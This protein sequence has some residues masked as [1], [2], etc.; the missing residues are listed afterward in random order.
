MERTHELAVAHIVEASGSVD[1]LNPQSAEV[2][3]LVTTVAVSISETLLIGVLGY[4]PDVLAGTKVTFG[5]LQ[6]LGSLVLLM[7]ND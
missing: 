5:L 6:N 2:A 1:T 3:L 4:R 7:L